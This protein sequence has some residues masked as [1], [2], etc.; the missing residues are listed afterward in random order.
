MLSAQRRFLL[1]ASAHRRN[2]KIKFVFATCVCLMRRFCF[3]TP[4]SV[5]PHRHHSKS[6]ASRAIH[7]L[8]K[9]VNFSPPP[10]QLPNTHPLPTP[11]TKNSGGIEY[12]TFF[13]CKISVW[14]LKSSTPSSY[15][16]IFRTSHC[17]LAVRCGMFTP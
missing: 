14:H 4:S 1:C 11:L 6:H 17:T 2:D 16:L 10:F 13:T 7:R 3:P 9:S 12:A 5:F 8:H 15:K